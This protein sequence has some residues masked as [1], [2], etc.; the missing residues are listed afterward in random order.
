MPTNHQPDARNLQ[1]L[2]GVAL[3]HPVDTK[4]PGRWR[5]SYP[6]DLGQGEIMW[7]AT[8]YGP[9][10]EEFHGVGLTRVEAMGAALD[11]ALAAD[12]C[13]G[14]LGKETL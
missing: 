8:T 7:A 12:Y 13:V 6:H 2:K 10:G 4:T 1:G 11:E 5:I 9:K 14:V 3:N